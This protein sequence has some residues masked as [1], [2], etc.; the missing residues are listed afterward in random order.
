[1]DEQA[2]KSLRRRKSKKQQNNSLQGNHRR[3]EEI[4]HLSCRPTPE[5]DPLHLSL[6]WWMLAQAEF[7]SLGFNSLKTVREQRLQD[8]QW[9]KAVK[10][11]G[12]QGLRQGWRSQ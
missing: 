1:M 8:W 6:S 5:Q 3:A 10:E 12:A 4:T 2:E 9:A 7:A 11:K